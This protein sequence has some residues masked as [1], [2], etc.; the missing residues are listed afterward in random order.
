MKTFQT[1][2]VTVGRVL[3]SIGGTHGGASLGALVREF[4]DTNSID[5]FLPW[6]AEDLV[7]GAMRVF[8]Q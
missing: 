3:S 8:L 1:L 7:T 6:Q 2:L 5:T 4:T